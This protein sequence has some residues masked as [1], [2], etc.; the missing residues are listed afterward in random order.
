M[1]EQKEVE[2]AQI[3]EEYYFGKGKKSLL[4]RAIDMN[5]L[6]LQ[7]AIVVNELNRKVNKLEDKIKEKNYVK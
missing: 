5:M 2:I 6:L 1:K 3:D 7:L 4:N